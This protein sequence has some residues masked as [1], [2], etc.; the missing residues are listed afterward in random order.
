MKIVGKV[1]VD[2]KPVSAI[3]KDK[4]LTVGGDVQRFHTQNV[5]RRIAKYLP[6]RSGA[7]IKLMNAQTNIEKPYII[8]EAPQAKYLYYGKVMVGRAPKTVTNRDLQY[9]KTKNPLA[10]AFWD[11]RLVAA[12]R[13][14]MQTEL[15]RYV[16]GK[17]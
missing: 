1:T 16:E 4:G 7:L 10:G 3:L 13:K 11:R 2:M 14:V 6:Y 17:R 15:Q 12:E 8:V 9:D 5:L